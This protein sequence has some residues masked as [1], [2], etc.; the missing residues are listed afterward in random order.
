MAGQELL[1]TQPAAFQRQHELRA[2]DDVVG[3]LRFQ[4]V[5]HRR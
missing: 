1:W 4:R 5:S 3:T 2:G